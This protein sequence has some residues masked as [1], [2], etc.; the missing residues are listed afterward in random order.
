MS[1]NIAIKIGL[2]VADLTAKRAIMSSELKTARKDLADFTAAARGS[3]E[4]MTPQ[5][6]QAATS[7]ATL[8]RQLRST[9]A[10]IRSY[11]QEAHGGGEAMGF[12]RTQTMIA[13]SAV[14]RFTDAVIAGASPV[15]AFALEAH[16]LG[17]IGSFDENGMSGAISK[18]LAYI[19]P[20]TVGVLGATAA[21]GYLAMK[22]YEVAAASQAAAEAFALT[23]RGANMT[24]DAVQGEIDR[25]SDMEG[26]SHSVAEALV[27]FDAAHGSVNL[28]IAYAANQLAPQ[29]I[30]AW[31]DK[32]PEALNQ[33]KQSL[34]DM[35]HGSLDE[36]VR[37]FQKLNESQLNLKPAEA[38]VVE[39]MI[40][41]GNTIGAVTRI[42]ADLAAQGGGHIQTINA[43]I[44]ETKQKLADAQTEAESMRAAMKM[45]TDPE[46]MRVFAASAAEADLRVRG[47]RASLL[48]LQAAAMQPISGQALED[49]VNRSHTTLMGLRD[50]ATKAKDALKE[51]HAEMEQRRDAN[52]KDP[53]VISYF[54][55]QKAIDTRL[56]KRENPEAF[57]KPKAP[58]GMESPLTAMEN[59]LRQQEYNIRQSTGDWQR[60]M[61]AMEAQYWKD[62]LDKAKAGSKLYGDLQAKFQEAQMRAG[63]RSASTQR[64][65]STSDIDTDL[66]IAQ[67]QSKDQQQAASAGFD[68][69]MKDPSQGIDADAKY[70]AMKAAI[71]AEAAAEMKAAEEKKELN[72]NDE[73]AVNAAANKEREINAD[74]QSKLAEL[75]RQRTADV[76]RQNE[77]RLKAEE[78]AAKK[79]AEVWREADQEIYSA[80]NQLISGIINGQKSMGQILAQLAAQLVERE[81]QADV[82][83]L[84]AKK[85]AAAQG[86]EVDK[87]EAEGGLLMHLLAARKKEAVTAT[88]LAQQS[89]QTAAAASTQTAVVQASTI[90]QTAA[91]TTGVATASAV[92]SA[93]N[94]AEI[95]SNAAVAGSGVF[96]ALA[97]IPV[98][99]PVLA[100]AAM[101]AAIAAVS[102]LAGSAGFAKGINEMPN[103]AIALIHA[104]ERIVPRAD[105]QAMIEALAG[106]GKRGDDARGDMHL[107]YAPTVNGHMPF[108]DQLAAHEDNIVSMIARLHRDDKL[109]FL[110]K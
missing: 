80:E 70:K 10:A 83:A 17:E 105:N 3:G 55:N 4:T 48:Q 1:N 76:Q 82:R 84:T 30:Q 59:D 36:A 56:E 28:Q 45:A 97:G 12:N 47:L 15:K 38:Q 101:P 25:L 22:E 68:L 8:E 31:G 67:T 72:A 29:F 23:G 16:K 37:A 7:V 69:H 42:L 108:G 11:G 110:R 107:H 60:D 20:L 5:M 75:E 54:A 26:V 95:G 27:A 78:D 73:T 71:E 24:A 18:L 65:I 98:V 106:N 92:G 39:G 46:G 40:E 49:A 58:K 50:G 74:L 35:A 96:K 44:A 77:A 109:S 63:S 85:L 91:K 9:N 21:Y 52:P 32:A 89:A 19:N 64:Q 6:L 93:A 14:M 57:K 104:G 86:T 2:D 103:D 41:S 13:Q 53:E 43:A 90:A 81:L 94:K 34:S 66:H 102:A 33:L 88:S 87:K 61:S 51:L 100:A 79:K 99:G 62:K